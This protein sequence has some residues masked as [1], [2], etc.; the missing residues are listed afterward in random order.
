MEFLSF[1]FSVADLSLFFLVAT[2]IGMAKMGVPGMGL[3]A[4]PLLA[5][6]FSGKESSGVLLIILCFA[7]IF[8]V[9]Y[10]HRHANWRQLIKLFPWAALGIIL[11]ALFGQWIDDQVFRVTMAIIIIASLILMVFT[12]KSISAKLPGVFWFAILLGILGGF[13]S[14]VGNLAGSV[15][16]L[17]FIAMNF[18]KNEFI[19]TTAWFFIIVNWFKIPF[20]IWSWGTINP[21]T[22]L[23]DLTAIPFIVL[24]AWIGLSIVKRIPEKTYRWFIILATSA[25]ALLMI[26]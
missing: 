7:D 11:G 19:G 4:V 21:D 3:A 23:L 5:L 13:T 10:Y 18:N 9:I 6:V 12:N 25:A 14:M 15:M 8:A 16:A 20:H 26:L 2:F 24:G 1:D 22:L 17:Y